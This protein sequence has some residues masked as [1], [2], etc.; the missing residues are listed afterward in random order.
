MAGVAEAPA[1]IRVEHV[2][3]R[4]DRIVARVVVAHERFAYTSPRLI[5]AL[6]PKYPHLL[7]HACVNDRGTTFAA[8]AADTSLPHLLEHMAIENQVRI[9][10]DSAAGF[11]HEGDGLLA[12]QRGVA[13]GAKPALFAAPRFSGQTYVGKTSWTNRAARRARVELN[14]AND[15]VALAALRDAVRDLNAALAAL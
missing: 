11:L 3:V 7:E 2:E 15:L 8:V 1:A 4:R 14:Y 13:A 10:E 9:E 12:G 6:L 5:A